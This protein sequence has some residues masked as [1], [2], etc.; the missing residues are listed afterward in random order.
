MKYV[1]KYSS[2]KN[3]YTLTNPKCNGAGWAYI[4][5]K[6]AKNSNGELRPGKYTGQSNTKHAY[7]LSIIRVLLKEYNI[8]SPKEYKKVFADI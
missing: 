2:I 1:I 5:H 4:V 3:K 8:E 7:H 6:Y